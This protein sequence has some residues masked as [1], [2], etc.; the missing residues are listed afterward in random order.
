VHMSIIFD[1]RFSARPRFPHVSTT[2]QSLFGGAKPN[3]DNTKKDPN[4]GPLPQE[5]WLED[6]PYAPLQPSEI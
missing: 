6:L 4:S 5:V 1:V 3:S 2:M